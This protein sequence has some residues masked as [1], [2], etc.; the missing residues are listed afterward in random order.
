MIGGCCP[1]R[2]RPAA[3]LLAA[4]LMAEVPL[5]ARAEELRPNEREF[6]EFEM[7]IISIAINCNGYHT[8]EAVLPKW[9]A[10]ADVRPE[11]VEAMHQ[12][13]QAASGI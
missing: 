5:S 12:V 7:T 2:H 6:V 8:I 11:V 10:V 3:I 9:A 4:L 13:L 1:R